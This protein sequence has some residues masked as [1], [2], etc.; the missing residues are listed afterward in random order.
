MKGEDEEEGEDELGDDDKCRTVFGYYLRRQ[1]FVQMIAL[2]YD[3][4]LI[5][6]RGL[7]CD[8]DNEKFIQ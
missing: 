1:G 8:C 6:A 7:S 5:F 2:L 3:G 4:I